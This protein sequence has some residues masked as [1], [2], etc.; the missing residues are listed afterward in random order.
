MKK[1][2]YLASPFFNEEEVGFMDQTLQGLRSK[3]YEVFAPFE[4]QNKELEFGSKVWRDKTYSGDITGIIGADVVVAIVS[5]GNYSD[6][7]TAWECG[8]AHALGIPV[9]VVNYTGKALNLMISDSLTAYHS[10]LDGLLA[11]DFDKLERKDYEEY[12]W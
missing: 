1:K 11:Y 12:V 6:S 10:D 5:G 4:H 3:G 2:I 8:Y 9:V 7:G